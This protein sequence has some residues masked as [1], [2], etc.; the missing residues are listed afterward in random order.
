MNYKEKKLPDLSRAFDVAPPVFTN[1]IENTLKQLQ[2]HEESP[3]MKKKI[4]SALVIAFIILLALTGVVYAVSF[5]P[6]ADSYGYKSEETKQAILSGNSALIGQSTTL[7]DVVYT[8]LEF[9]YSDGRIYGTA[10]AK[11]LPGTNWL[12][13]PSG[14]AIDDPVRYKDV[15]HDGAIPKDAIT[16]EQLA[17]DN[18]LTLLRVDLYPVS[19][20]IKYTEQPNNGMYW[21]ITQP[22]NSVQ[23][24]FEFYTDE[25]E[26]PGSIPENDR[27][28]VLL[29][30]SNGAALKNHD[31]LY[32]PEPPD[33]TSPLT[34]YW[35]V[36]FI[37]QKKE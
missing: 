20:I 29:E 16:Y 35:R 30:I 10:V 19:Y 34:D 33:E 23:I 12:L 3:V 28:Q 36:D 24:T 21:G 25:Y 11:P 26:E 4:S 8:L 37:P 2:N 5:T 32:F 13:I 6:T 31:Y 27:Y 18:S 14:C 15:H 7:G 22:D 9:V 1:G 17:K